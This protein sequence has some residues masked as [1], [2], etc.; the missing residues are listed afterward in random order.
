[1]R[2]HHPI[3]LHLELGNGLPLKPHAHYMLKID[4]MHHVYQKSTLMWALTHFYC[5]SLSLCQGAINW[6][7]K[8]ACLLVYGHLLLIHYKVQR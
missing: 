5:E 4:H 8:W 7:W 6:K 1:M 3:C 2:F